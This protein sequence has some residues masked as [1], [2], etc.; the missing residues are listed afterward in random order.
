[1]PMWQNM[2]AYQTITNNPCPLTNAELLL[3]SRMDYTMRIL[4]CPLVLVVNIDDAV[5]TET[6]LICKEH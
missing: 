4:V 1:M 2:R 6:W 3:V 5:S